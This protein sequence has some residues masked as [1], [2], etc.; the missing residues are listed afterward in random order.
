MN[1][2]ALESSLVE[3]KVLGSLGQLVRKQ[4][5]TSTLHLNIKTP[6]DAIKLIGCQ[7]DGF[8]HALETAHEKGIAFRLVDADPSG[9]SEEELIFPCKRLVLSPVASGKGGFGKILLG[10]ALVATAFLVPGGILGVSSLTIGLLG[11]SLILQGVAGLLTKKPKSE[12]KDSSS[13]LINGGL[14]SVNQGLPVPVLYGRW[15]L[16]NLLVISYQVN[17]FRI[18]VEDDD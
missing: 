15:L 13:Q 8:I 17:V 6:V 5:G 2:I 11:G 3:V 14:N 4:F 12:K 9:M 7:V 18:A 16:E 1:A 10:V